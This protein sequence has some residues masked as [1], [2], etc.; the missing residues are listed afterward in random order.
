MGVTGT[1]G[2][3]VIARDADLVIGIGTRYSDFTSASKTA[4]QNPDVRFL[5]INVAEFD[6][7]KHAAL[8]VVAD[9]KAALDELATWLADTEFLP[10]SPVGS[11]PI[12]RNGSAKW[13]GS[14]VW[15]MAP[16]SARER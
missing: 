6:A 10:N 12:V 15:A 13:T 11:A 7:Y 14:T 3:N 5:N 16:R 8:P 4:F 1:P 9:A 2:A